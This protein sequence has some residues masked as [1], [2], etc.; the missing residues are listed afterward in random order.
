VGCFSPDW[1]WV[2]NGAPVNFDGEPGANLRNPTVGLAAFNFNRSRR[3]EE[4][5]DGT[6]QTV[7]A[8]ELIAGPDGTADLRGKWW[9]EFGVMYVHHLPPNSPRPDEVESGHCPRYCDA[10]KAPIVGDTPAWKL[11]NFAARSYHP[12]GVNALRGDGSVRWERD[13]IDPRV[14]QALAS[15]NSGEVI[16]S[17]AD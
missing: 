13:T 14:W 8:S 11:A 12:G 7:I 15:I 4:I 10:S 5:T 6:S 1:G 9:H 3:L 16:A 2:E 17:G